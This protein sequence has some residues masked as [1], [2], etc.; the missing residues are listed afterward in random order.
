MGE[1]YLSA[2]LSWTISP[3]HREW[4][5]RECPNA[6]LL[7][8]ENLGPQQTRVRIAAGASRIDVEGPTIFGS[9]MSLIESDQAI[10]WL[11]HEARLYVKV[12]RGDFPP[13]RPGRPVELTS[14][15]VDD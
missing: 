12:D 7:D 1:E 3:A 5:R 13:L 15:K 11:Q 10:L 9:G 8:L 4:V 2:S 6:W 14:I